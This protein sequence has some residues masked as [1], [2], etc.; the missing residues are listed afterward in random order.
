MRFEWEEV[1]DFLRE[2]WDKSFYYLCPDLEEE[3]G[4]LLSEFY[5]SKGFNEGTVT[6]KGRLYNKKVL[7]EIEMP[8]PIGQIHNFHN[9]KGWQILK[10]IRKLA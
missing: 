3:N 5:K 7:A 2:N 6:N 9:L 10:N 8:Y 4:C 1:E